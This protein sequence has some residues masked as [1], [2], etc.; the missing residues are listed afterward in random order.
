MHAV[1][2]Y[3]ADFDHQLSCGS[4][5]LETLTL[6]IALESS[7][8]GQQCTLKPVYSGH[9]TAAVAGTKTVKEIAVA[10]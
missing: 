2:I 9:I 5:P 4:V 6:K 10:K 3:V 8:S 1:F 7:G